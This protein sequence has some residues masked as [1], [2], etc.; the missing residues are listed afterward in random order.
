MKRIFHV[1]I[2]NPIADAGVV[3]VVVDRPIIEAEAGP[4]LVEAG[5]MEARRPIEAEGVVAIVAVV[6]EEEGVAVVHPLP[7]HLRRTSLDSFLGIYRYSVFY[8]IYACFHS[9]QH[10]RLLFIVSWGYLT[11]PIQTCVHRRARNYDLDKRL[12][13]ART[14]VWMYVAHVSNVSWRS[15]SLVRE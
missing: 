2:D 3:L 4:P 11:S 8:G 10:N 1:K 13:T 6:V 9:H 7:Q 14:R 12:I 15:I 5:L